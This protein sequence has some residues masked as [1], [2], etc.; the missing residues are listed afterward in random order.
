MRSQAP[1][2]PEIGPRGTDHAQKEEVSDFPA[3]SSEEAKVMEE[4]EDEMQTGEGPSKKRLRVER[5]KDFEKFIRSTLLSGGVPL[6]SVGRHLMQNLSMLRTKF[7]QFF[8]NFE[9]GVVD[10]V[11]ASGPAAP[12]LLPI[13]IVGVQESRIGRN[14]EV[15]EWMA[16]TCLCLNFW[17]C[18]GWERPS[19]TAHPRELTASQK[20]FLGCHLCPA[21]ERM[22]EGDPLIPSYSELET[23]LS[24]K[25]QD[26]EGNTWVVMEQLEAT[27]V[28][29]CWPEKGKA[30]VQPLQKFL[31]GETRELIEA[32]RTTILPYEEWPE[33]IPK[34]Y[35][36]ATTEEWEKLVAEGYER[37]LFQF[38]PESEV[39]VGPSGEKILNGAGAV[40]KEKNGEILQRFISIFCPLN[41]VSRKVEGEE[42]SLPYVGQV[43]LIN[44]PDEASILVDSEDLESAFNLFEMPLGWRGLFCY[45]KKV[46]GSIL[47]L[48]SEEEV[49]VSL[50]TVPMGWVSAVGVVQA[51][52]RHLAFEVAGL[53]LQGEL[54]KGKPVPG[55]DKF[56]LYLDSV[57]QLRVVDQTCK[58]IVE[59][60][61]SEEH[62]KFE[63]ACDSMGLPRNKGKALAGALRGT[64]QGGELRGEE[65]VFMLQPKKMHQNVAL[66]LALLSSQTWDQRRT[67]GII[68]R[69][70]FA[71][72]FR[73]PFI[74]CLA[75]V[76]HHFGQSK[77][78]TPSD[79]A[80]DEILGI[81]G[82][83]PMAF[84]NLKAPVNPMMHATDASPT[85]A[86]SCIAKQMKRRP[87]TANSADLTCGVCGRDI[88]EEMAVAEEIDC[89]KKCGGHYCSLECYL[90]HRDSCPM[91]RLGVPCFSERWSG[92]N[93]PLTV[94]MLRRGFDVLPPYDRERVGR[95][96]FFTEEGK[97]EWAQ[98]DQEDPDYEHHAPDCKT[99]TRARGRPFYI[100][101]VRYEGP[102]AL[103]R[104]DSNVMGFRNLKGADAVKVRQGNKMALAS[105]KRCE[106]LDD[107]QKFFS[108]EHPYRSFIWGLNR[109]KELAK[110][111]GVIMAVFSNCCHGG[112]R[113]KWTCIITNNRGI[114]EALNQ[115]DCP[116]GPGESYQPYFEGNKLIF[117]T[118]QEAE[119]PKLLC[120]R[121]AEG[122]AIDLGLDQH[123]QAAH[124]EV[125][126]EAV[127]KELATYHR[128]TDPELRRRMVG[129]ILDIENT[130]IPGQ[131]QKHLEWLLAQGHYRGT[132]VRLALDYCGAK[133]M[134]PYPALRWLWRETLSFR[135]KVDAHIN[136]L[137][138]Q[139]LLAHVRR[140]MRDPTFRSC[141][142]MVVIDSQDEEEETPSTY[143]GLDRLLSD[144]LEHMWLDD[145]PITYAGHLLSGL[146]RYLPESRWRTPRA[147]QYFANWQ[148]VH[149]SRQAAPL[150]AQ[151]VMALAGLALATD[152]PSIAALLL[153]GFL[154]FLRTGEM[155]HL[156]AAKIAVDKARGRIL[157]ALPGTKT[158]RGREETVCVQDARVTRLVAYVL[159]RGISELWQGS[160]RSFR[161]MLAEF[162][163]FLSLESFGFTGYSF[164]RG[165]ASFAFSTGVSFDELLVKGRWQNARTAR[166]YLDTGRAALIQTRFS[167]PVSHLLDRYAAKLRSFCDQLR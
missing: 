132:D 149:V 130:M 129:T 59:G 90:D 124:L 102:K 41:S 70:I 58:A 80:Y 116:H 13:S 107:E 138:A 159:N 118:E 88:T 76:F 34:S 120:T 74:S 9:D 65:G 54:Q 64:I 32:P 165:G 38:C 86:G 94:A 55:G 148:S 83:L 123:V 131:E 160:P 97:Q 122:A 29:R 117:P 99:F 26:Y 28:A 164:R 153:L 134:V 85:G 14:S 121:Y 82:L 112:T 100:E 67:S 11:K 167:P 92:P 154:A 25:G 157:I 110:R 79:A 139:A 44:V 33:E 45:E 136:I 150:P 145:E 146:R 39:L 10:Q 73:R 16:L 20:E 68:G 2:E 96:D 126:A 141:R 6:R 95:M 105:I 57:D 81:V 77:E 101:G 161:A 53:P 127:D 19:H 61:A 52:I 111:P 21:I 93:A 4:E 142:M 63:A 155:V 7:G 51:A 1:P 48:P 8:E 84:T 78:R 12:D 18:T 137:E 5:R 15:T 104:D 114:F 3:L 17:Y 56:L 37:G 43:L 115:R 24:Q 66:C 128:C 60:T 143:R 69:L 152:Q 46:R 113:E 125:R 36:R 133:H 22:L 75:Q 163:T 140:M 98:L 119:Y 71:G 89:P 35:V 158:S 27:K 62:K 31:K 103:R 72:A 151:A 156:S 47:G 144:Y 91:R 166:L 162:F 108:L 42:G 23:L 147:K 40:P 30:S 135:W 106:D 50:R 49:Y 87:G 109:M